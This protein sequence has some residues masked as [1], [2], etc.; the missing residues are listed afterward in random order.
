[1]M[2]HAAAGMRHGT[3]LDNM[4]QSPGEEV[5]HCKASVV[6][7]LSC[8]PPCPAVKLV[9]RA[10]MYVKVRPTTLP[11]SSDVFLIIV[12]CFLPCCEALV[13]HACSQVSHLGFLLVEC[14]VVGR[15]MLLLGSGG[16]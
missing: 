15:P 12:S 6:H 5:L 13:C 4:A 9:P 16:V 8:Q 10:F 14:G 1:M 11:G 2:G 7:W 3:C